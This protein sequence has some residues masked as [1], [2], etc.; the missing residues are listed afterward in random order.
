MSS[1]LI[2]GSVKVKSWSQQR[3]QL[4]CCFTASLCLMPWLR[5]LFSQS[6]WVGLVVL[7]SPQSACLSRLCCGVG[8]PC[9]WRGAETGSNR[10]MVQ[11]EAACPP[12][13]PADTLS[14][15]DTNVCVLA[16]LCVCVCERGGGRRKQHRENHT[17]ML[18]LQNRGQNVFA[19]NTD[20]LDLC[21]CVLQPW[22]K[23]QSAFCCESVSIQTLSRPHR[24]ACTDRVQSG[25]EFIWYKSSQCK[26]L[27]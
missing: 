4:F 15:A 14:R 2:T 18:C 27:K 17:S 22:R 3:C 5:S 8:M 11:H 23:Q 16:S 13:A 1:L 9:T 25:E 6:V 21:Y 12:P 19:V 20:S 10:R 7:R 26:Y 24:H